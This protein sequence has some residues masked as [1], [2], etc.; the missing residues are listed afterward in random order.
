MKST[1]VDES[2]SYYKTNVLFQR[3]LQD[4]KIVDDILVIGYE[5]NG[6]DHDAAVHKVLQ[7]C[8]EV[9][10]K[11]NKEKCHLRCISIPFLWQLI[12]RRGVQ[13]DPQKIKALT[14]ILASNKKGTP[15][16]PWYY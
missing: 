6:A 15:G 13:P 11:F 2:L 5:E 8:E 3:I 4:F 1:V 10:F 12:S 16:L 14:D 7:R 9:N